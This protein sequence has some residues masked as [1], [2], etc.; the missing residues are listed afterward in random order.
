[1]N[2]SGS[3][4]LCGSA[5]F[6][7]MVFFAKELDELAEKGAA[8]SGFLLWDEQQAEENDRW[9]KYDSAV[10]WRAVGFATV[11]PE[12]ANRIAVALGSKGQYFEVDTQSLKEQVGT[13]QKG[14]RGLRSSRNVGNT[15][16][17]AG[18]GRV[19]LRRVSVGKWIEFGP[20]TKDSEADL[21]I[22]F[23]DLAGFS[24]S[25]LY[26]V[27]WGGEIWWF[28]GKKWSQID[29][30]TSGNLNAL[31]C[32]SDGV[33]YIVGDDGIMLHGRRDKWQVIETGRPENLMDV[34]AYEGEV[35]VVTDFKILQLVKKR[36]VPA[37]NFVSKDV[38]ATCLHLLE[39]TDGIVS[40][41]PKDLF[42]LHNVKWE[43][44]V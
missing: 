39:A 28:N 8:N 44:V 19:A 14:I 25:D 7:D 26:A 15:I 42:R 3:S 16:Y 21:V 23:E 10:Q 22:G 12:G 34:A 41:G 35:Y 40:M 4:F 17:C 43:R 30:P 2:H 27:G 32:A 13:I 20:G 18:M 24:E 33:V 31:T 36:L 5:P 1:M 29:S 11:K 9:M 6:T 38:P 37:K